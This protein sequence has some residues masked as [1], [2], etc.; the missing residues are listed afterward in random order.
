LTHPLL[1]LGELDRRARR[2]RSARQ[3]L[4]SNPRLGL[5]KEEDDDEGKRLRGALPSGRRD[6][7]MRGISI[8]VEGAR[9]VAVVRRVKRI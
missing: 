9:R 4:R 1:G 8:K 3:R 5:R 7:H 6:L 2:R